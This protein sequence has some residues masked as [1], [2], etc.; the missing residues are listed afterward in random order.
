MKES[1]QAIHIYGVQ[2]CG[3]LVFLKIFSKKCLLPV[4]YFTFPTAG[5]FKL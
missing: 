2:M 1:S 4:S 5:Y 3:A